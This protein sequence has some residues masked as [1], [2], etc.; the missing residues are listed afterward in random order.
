MRVS[1]TAKAEALANLRELLKPG[2]KVY[3]KVTHVA[4]SGMSRSIECFV[5][6]D[7]EPRNISY[8]GARA[9]GE[10]L[11]DKN[12][13]VRVGGCGM[14]MCFHTVYCLSSVLFPEGFTCLGDGDYSR[15]CPSN[16]H[17]N[18][19]RNYAPHHHASG[20]YALRYS[21]L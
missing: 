20:G 13:G 4:R 18:G 5:I 9:L 2:D 1:K 21:D 10:R 12:G 17:S 11:D 19:D 7:N 15:R 16:D 6:R 8:L 14:N 3:T